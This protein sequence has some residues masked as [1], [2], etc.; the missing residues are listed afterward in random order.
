MS[1]LTE[2]ELRA[3]DEEYLADLARERAKR[4]AQA[5]SAQGPVKEREKAPQLSPE[6]ALL[7]DK[8][9]RLLDMVT[10]GRVEALRYLAARMSIPAY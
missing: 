9:T 6:E 4:L 1:H 7:R 8:W 3:Q 2:E 5:H 10:K